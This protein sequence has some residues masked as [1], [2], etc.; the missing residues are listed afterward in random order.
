MDSTEKLGEE[1]LDFGSLIDE[2]KRQKSLLQL[3]HE[4]DTTAQIVV[5]NVAKDFRNAQ[6]KRRNTLHTFDTQASSDH[7]VFQSLRNFSDEHGETLTVQ[8]D[9]AA[10]AHSKTLK[11]AGS[12]ES[13]MGAE[14]GAKLEIAKLKRE[15]AA[16]E[17]EKAGYDQQ[18]G[19]KLKV[20]EQLEV[21]VAT[22]EESVILITSECTKAETDKK[23]AKAQLDESKAANKRIDKEQ[24]TEFEAVHSRIKEEEATIKNEATAQLEALATVKERHTKAQQSLEAIDQNM[25]VVREGI[26]NELISFGV[27]LASKNEEDDL[28]L[29][30]KSLQR[31][32]D[33]RFRELERTIRK[34]NNKL[35]MH[36]EATKQFLAT[37]K[38]QQSRIAALNERVAPHENG[39][40]TLSNSFFKAEG[41]DIENSDSDTDS[42]CDLSAVDAPAEG[43]QSPAQTGKP[44]EVGPITSPGPSQ[45]DLVKQLELTVANLTGDLAT[46]RRRLKEAN[47]QARKSILRTWVANAQ[48]TSCRSCQRP[49][50]LFVWRNHC[51]KCG[52]V[53][54]GMCCSRKVITTFNQKPERVC[55]EC[56]F[57]TLRLQRI[58]KLK[59]R[60]SSSNL[61]EGA[62]SPKARKE[63]TA[64][65][66]TETHRICYSA[67]CQAGLPTRCYSVDCKYNTP[68]FSEM[69]EK[70]FTRIVRALKAEILQPGEIINIL[71]T[72]IYH[73]AQ[74]LRV[75]P[76]RWI[77]LVRY[78]LQGE[79]PNKLMMQ[80]HQDISDCTTRHA[81]HASFKLVK[82][83]LEERT[84]LF[85]VFDMKLIEAYRLLSVDALR[86]CSPPPDENHQL[87]ATDAFGP[88][89]AHA[90]LP[91]VG[92]HKFDLPAIDTRGR[93]GSITIVH[94]GGA[95][96]YSKADDLDDALEYGE[97]LSAVSQEVPGSPARLVVQ[98]E[99][100]DA[101]GVR[102]GTPKRLMF[103][104]NTATWAAKIARSPNKETL[105]VVGS[106]LKRLTTASSPLALEHELDLPL[107]RANY[108]AKL[109]SL[110]NAESIGFFQALDGQLADTTQPP[111]SKETFI[112]PSPPTVVPA[113]P[114]GASTPNGG[115]IFRTQH[116]VFSPHFLFSLLR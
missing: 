113:L 103:E 27:M 12:L 57:D 108:S 19:E 33:E 82:V 55:Q 10:A 14:K 109:Q 38:I 79:H 114:V 107:L 67:S 73:V 21:R 83:Q 116:F 48:A 1:F 40:D 71:S 51:R 56:F 29:L 53:F 13:R 68:E 54:C 106:M 99:E 90:H 7:A 61:E 45:E 69:R 112:V 25:R 52:Q 32:F 80:F 47:V 94:A 5:D 95:V 92:G 78:V 44:D 34:L 37:I 22:A 46:L 23:S 104:T 42:W 36:D 93:S 39:A 86:L 20:L 70:K 77:D 76:S 66:L 60:V 84:T 58:R 16:A 9:E 50:D 24:V 105:S 30:L 96:R 74:Q 88:S 4:V 15:F 3:Y 62:Q 85:N 63:Q 101:D 72:D 35:Q 31:G 89:V 18:H 100:D 110:S 43:M 8:A 17:K 28:D 11:L 87:F 64:P 111:S 41:S 65:E 6:D 115:P 49:F 102:Y 91:K 81:L 98:E 59:Q 26:N 2:Y 97:G 75:A